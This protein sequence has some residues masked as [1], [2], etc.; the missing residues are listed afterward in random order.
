MLSG[1]DE[2]YLARWKALVDIYKSLSI[3]VFRDAEAT[4]FRELK[5]G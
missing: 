5:L 1:L 2:E 3:D 4:R